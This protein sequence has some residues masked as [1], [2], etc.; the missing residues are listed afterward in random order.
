MAKQRFQ[1]TPA[2][3]ILAT[4]VILV[5]SSCALQPAV[6]GGL[7]KIAVPQVALSQGGTGGSASGWVLYY[8]LVPDAEYTLMTQY[9]IN[10]PII[11]EFYGS[12]PYVMG[13]IAVGTQSESPSSNS[14]QYITIEG[15]PA[16]KQVHLIVQLWNS[17]DSAAN[18]YYVIAGSSYINAWVYESSSY[19]D[20]VEGVV[21]T[22]TL[23]NS[24]YSYSLTYYSC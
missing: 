21:N 15:L 14:T 8:L 12:D 6:E 18:P 17:A 11:S 2:V 16:K 19:F 1:T 10:R 9:Q 23:N 24:N 13:E 5:V 22:V 20:I 3:A 4:L 7:V